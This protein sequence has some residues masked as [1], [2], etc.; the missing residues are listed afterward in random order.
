MLPTSE[1]R[2]SKGYSVPG[3]TQRLAE[4]S[5]EYVGSWWVKLMDAPKTDHY[6]KVIMLH[7]TSTR[8]ERI[9]VHCY[10]RLLGL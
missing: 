7:K 4:Y 3:D 2:P 9:C 6:I 10:E 5:R 8:V 1:E